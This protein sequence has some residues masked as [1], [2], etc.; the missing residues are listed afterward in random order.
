[1]RHISQS[2]METDRC[3]LQRSPSSFGHGVGWYRKIMEACTTKCR[4]SWWAFCRTHG[5]PR[6][7]LSCSVIRVHLETLAQQ[8]LVV[9]RLTTW[10]TRPERIPKSKILAIP[11][12]VD[13]VLPIPVRRTLKYTVNIQVRRLLLRVP[14]DSPPPS[15]P[16]TP[17]S[18]DSSEDEEEGTPDGAPRRD[19]SRE[20]RSHRRARDTVQTPPPPEHVPGSSMSGPQLDGDEDLEASETHVPTT[21]VSTFNASQEASGDDMVCIQNDAQTLSPAPQRSHASAFTPDPTMS[22]ETLR[23]DVPSRFDPMQ[24]EVNLLGRMEQQSSRGIVAVPPPTHQQGETNQPAQPLTTSQETSQG[25]VGPLP[26]EAPQNSEHQ[27]GDEE[28]PLSVERHDPA[29]QEDHPDAR[30]QQFL[31]EVTVPTDRPTTLLATPVPRVR[32]A[33]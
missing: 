19:R 12:P 17:P 22:A 16:A 7:R 6:P 10:T 28:P 23:H 31:N 8:D 15:P 18:T 25:Q 26:Q 20:R 32:T 21:L 9:F 1:M 29:T 14:P 33:P 24:E 2:S 13:D 4:S 11:E 5:T 27:S 3:K 30:G